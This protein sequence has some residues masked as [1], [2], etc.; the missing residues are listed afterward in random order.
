MQKTRH[1][2]TVK[3]QEI[4]FVRVSITTHE[5]LGKFGRKEEKYGEIV[6]RLLDTVEMYEGK[7]GKIDV[8][9]QAGV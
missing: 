6:K 2:N 9:I 4:K 5:R 7:Y 1:V 8:E 3:S